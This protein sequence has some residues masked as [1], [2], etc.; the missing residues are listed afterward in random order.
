MNPFI[1][2]VKKEL[3]LPK[4]VAF[5]VLGLLLLP[6]VAYFLRPYLKKAPVVGNIIGGPGAAAALMLGLLLAFSAPTYAF[7]AASSPVPAV[8]V[9]ASHFMPDAAPIFAPVVTLAT[10]AP[11]E[12]L[13]SLIWYVAMAAIL[14]VA[15]VLSR[16]WMRRNWKA[17][18][19]TFALLFAVV[20]FAAPRFQQSFTALV[21]RPIP[22]S[23]D[24]TN[25]FK[26][27]S[28]NGS[29][30]LMLDTNNT[31]VFFGPTGWETGYTG[32]LKLTNALGSGFSTNFVRGGLITKTNV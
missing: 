9:Q 32:Q 3:T 27:Y 19:G 6:F 24:N 21:M 16:H 29:N 10:V 11:G 2:N 15:L 22:G 4:I 25:F 31:F 26:L 1:D 30:F 17:L 23:Y 13:F 5:L 7:D 28:A 18:S 12:F 8:T 20:C 14:S